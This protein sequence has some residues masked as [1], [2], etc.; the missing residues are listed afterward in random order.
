M[1]LRVTSSQ[2]RCQPTRSEVPAKTLSYSTR[3]EFPY[4]PSF[5]VHL[6][7]HLLTSFYVCTVDNKKEIRRE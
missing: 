7:F 6:H 1:G 2:F 3:G 4:F 5:L